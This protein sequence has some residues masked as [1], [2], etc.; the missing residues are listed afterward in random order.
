MT[1]EAGGNTFHS[2]DISSSLSCKATDIHDLCLVNTL[3]WAE[4]EPN[5]CY[6]L[7]G[8]QYLSH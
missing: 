6:S 7:N 3:I 5:V 2:I 4:R 1:N 8:F